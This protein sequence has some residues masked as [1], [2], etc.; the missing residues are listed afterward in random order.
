MTA[1]E[2]K[3]YIELGKWA[4][5]C[6][7][8]KELPEYPNY[9]RAIVFYRNNRVCVEFYPLIFDVHG[10]T[11]SYCGKFD[12]IQE[13]V[14]S[15]EFFL[16]KSVEEWTN[17]NKS[18]EFPIYVDEQSNLEISQDS[19]ERLMQ[20]A[21]DKKISLPNKGNFKLD[22]KMHFQNRN[23]YE[24][25]LED[26]DDLTRELSKQATITYGTSA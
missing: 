13:A 4:S 24:R 6:V 1:D 3:N 9:V 2:I 20:N 17:Y 10:A 16:E 15:V 5:V 22:W 7:D 8:I 12:S 19:H 25:F 11:V 23:Q 21:C 18:G 26:L 14:N